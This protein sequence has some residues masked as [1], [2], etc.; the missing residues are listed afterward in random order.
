MVGVS[1]AGESESGRWGA[2]SPQGAAAPGAVPCSLAQR[3]LPSFTHSVPP[4]HKF[5]FL[6]HLKEK[7]SLYPT[8]IIAISL[9][10]CT[11]KLFERIVP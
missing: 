3:W 4:A 5:F 6:S 8:S 10:H 7:P 2:G 11:A 1:R 9:H